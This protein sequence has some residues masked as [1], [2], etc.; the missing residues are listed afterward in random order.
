M[1]FWGLALLMLASA[2]DMQAIEKRFAQGCQLV[3][4]SVNT[5][6]PEQGLSLYKRKQ[7]LFFRSDTA[8]VEA[9]SNNS[10]LNNFRIATELEALPVDDQFAYDDYADVIYFTSLGKL[11]S[12]RWYEE[13]WTRQKRVK[14]QG[15]N[16]GIKVP[17]TDTLGNPKDIKSICHPNLARKGE[18]LYF[19]AVS[20]GRTDMDLWYAD[21]ASDGTWQ[22]PHRLSINTKANEQHPFVVADT[23]LYFSS[24]RSEN[25][26]YNLYY[27]DLRDSMPVA[28]LSVLS[29]PNSDEFSMVAVGDWIHVLSNRCKNDA[30]EMCDVNIYK[31]QL[32]VANFH[33]GGAISFRPLV[34]AIPADTFAPGRAYGFKDKKEKKE[35]PDFEAMPVIFHAVSEAESD[36]SLTGGKS[37]VSSLTAAQRAEEKAKADSLLH[38][39]LNSAT[40]NTSAVKVSKNV[41]ATQSKRIF[42]FDTDDDRIRESYAEDFNM[43]INYINSNP[44]SKFLIY[45]FTDER[46]TTAYN[47]DLSVRR[48]QRVFEELVAKGVPATKLMFTGFGKRGLVVKNAKT[49]AEHQMNRR[50]EIRKADF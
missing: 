9:V 33:Q 25:H 37:G 13:A 5:Y 30:N 26:R 3:Y 1:K 24:D 39:A 48:A 43:L 16:K 34:E 21:K 22:A 35:E 2:I 41:T 28:R 4:S 42:Y 32:P 8:Y 31:A 18:R 19:A 14:M 29:N 11:Y 15:V 7:V 38:S 49:E 45:G 36:S 12:S 47:Q 27:V 6:G 17:Y 50:V 20:K 40:E 44:D 46:G 23:L 10:D